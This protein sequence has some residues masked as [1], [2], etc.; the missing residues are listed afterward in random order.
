M[1]VG[2]TL[3][4]VGVMMFSLS[5]LLRSAH[6]QADKG[7]ALLAFN[8]ETAPPA[9]KEKEAPAETKGD[10]SRQAADPKKATPP[11]MSPAL[12]WANLLLEKGLNW[13]VVALFFLFCFRKQLR[14]LIA[15]LT[16]AFADRGVTLEVD[17]ANK[18]QS[19]LKE[20]DRTS[21]KGPIKD[22]KA[23]YIREVNKVLG[24]VAA[25]HAD[26]SELNPRSCSG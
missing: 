11:P 16:D 26:Y 25:F 22:N 13:V 21:Q 7:T 14:A 20:I 9:A 6:G 19:V 12:Q 15:G 1:K 8:D 2:R 24:T 3:G 5:G 4:I 10:A 23:Y 17:V 18:A